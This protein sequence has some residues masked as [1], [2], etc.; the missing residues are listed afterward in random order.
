[1]RRRP[2]S[3]CDALAMQTYFCRSEQLH[4]QRVP[5]GLA[6]LCEEEE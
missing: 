2:F 4:I 3:V 5:K 1:M 6:V